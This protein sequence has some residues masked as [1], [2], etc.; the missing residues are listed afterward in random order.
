MENLSVTES[1]KLQEVKEKFMPFLY[2]VRRRFFVTVIFFILST[3][4][5]FIFYERIIRVLIELLSLQGVNIV[6]TSPFQ[7]INLAIACGISSGLVLT[8]PLILY[9]L[10]SFIRPALKKYEYKLVISLIPFSLFL[11]VFGF[12]FGALVMKWQ[13]EIFLARSVSLGIGNIL[14]IS[15]LLTT[16]VMTAALMGLL[17]EF[18]IVLL[19]LLKIGIIKRKFLSKYRYYIYLISFIVAILLPPDSILADIL[20]SLPLIILFE[21]TLI[22]DRFLKRK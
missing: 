14:D 7:F 2:E 11:F 19:L 17:F 16:V 10:L 12:C 21:F 18:P 3:V 6:F 8:F 22:L 9:Q 4:F 5:G 13:I 15:S 20:L 1:L